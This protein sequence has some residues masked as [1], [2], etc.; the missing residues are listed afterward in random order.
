MPPTAAMWV[1]AGAPK[2]GAVY[3]G[4]L[5]HTTGPPFN[6]MPFLPSN[7]VATEAARSISPSRTARADVRV[8][9]RWRDPNKAITR[10]I[11]VAPGTICQ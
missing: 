8:H 1:F 4:A 6:A 7:V 2:T 9:A 10:Q 5:Y 3:A 11:L